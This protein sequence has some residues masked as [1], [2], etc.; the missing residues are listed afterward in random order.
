MTDHETTEYSVQQEMVH[1]H[2]LIQ[3]RVVVT[4]FRTERDKAPL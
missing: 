4:I 2:L 1:V 3:E